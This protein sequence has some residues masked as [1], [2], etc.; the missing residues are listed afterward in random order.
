MLS[1]RGANL[2]KTVLILVLLVFTFGNM[3]TGEFLIVLLICIYQY[4]REII[5]LLS[6]LAEHSWF[7]LCPGSWTAKDGWICYGCHHF[8]SGF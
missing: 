6:F 1:R 7:P 5:F 8:L 4:C 3:H 2:R